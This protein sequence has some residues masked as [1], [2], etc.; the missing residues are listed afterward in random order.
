MP[1]IFS[2]RSVNALSMSQLK[3]WSIRV[4]GGMVPFLPR[5]HRDQRPKHSRLIYGNPIQARFRYDHAC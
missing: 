3:I 5:K 2:A 1:F 4:F